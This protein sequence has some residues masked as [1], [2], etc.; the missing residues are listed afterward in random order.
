MVPIS[1]TGTYHCYLSNYCKLIKTRFFITSTIVN[2]ELD[3]EVDF[4]DL[5]IPEET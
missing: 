1:V 3:N 4:V 2:Q 5:Y